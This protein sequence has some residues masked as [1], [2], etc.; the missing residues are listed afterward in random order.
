MYSIESSRALSLF[1]YTVVV[2]VYK[3]CTVVIVPGICNL[4][5]CCDDT[6][7]ILDVLP[8]IQQELELTAQQTDEGFPAPLASPFSSTPAVSTCRTPRA[9]VGA[10]GG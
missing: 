10:E 4:F 5:S 1:T 7:T 3:H 6:L 9:R 8:D 2:L